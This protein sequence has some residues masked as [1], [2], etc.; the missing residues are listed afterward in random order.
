V[1]PASVLPRSLLPIVARFVAAAAPSDVENATGLTRE[2]W[3]ALSRRFPGLGPRAGARAARARKILGILTAAAIST[4][5]HAPDWI[6]PPAGV[7]PTLWVT[8]H[9]GDLRSLRYLL[10]MRGIPAAHIVDPSHRRRES[11]ARDD[12]AF[13]RR[14]PIEFPHVVFSP[15]VHRVRSLL[16]R[17]SLIA[18]AD[19]PAGAGVGA[20]VLGGLLP[21]DPRPFR[22]ARIVAAPCRPIFL[23]LRGGR[24]ALVSGSDIPC[25]EPEAAAR[26]FGEVLAAAAADGPGAFDGFTHRRLAPE[27]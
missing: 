3:E 8:A 22:L 15:G 26:E 17:G 27:P 11:V 13:D 25:E 16:S 5:R 7:G 4:P 14:Y 6:G 12:E 19:R 1:S 9:H 2:H 20:T 10:R 24:L 23:T 18:A 21:L